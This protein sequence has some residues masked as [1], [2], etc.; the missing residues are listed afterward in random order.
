[1]HDLTSVRPSAANPL[2]IFSLT[3]GLIARH[4]RRS[5]AQADLD[6]CPFDARLNEWRGSK[7]RLIPT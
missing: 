3:R 2:I 5:T 4:D 1:M 6:D 7:W